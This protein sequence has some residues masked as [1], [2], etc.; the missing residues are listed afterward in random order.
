MI[1]AGG[2]VAGAGDAG[3]AFSAATRVV[4]ELQREECH[5]D[6]PA[7]IGEHNRKLAGE[8]SANATSAFSRGRSILQKEHCRFAMF[9]AQFIAKLSHQI[10]GSYHRLSDAQPP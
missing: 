7:A 4:F 3:A 6:E 10:S 8:C 2:G 5:E 1:F 9:G